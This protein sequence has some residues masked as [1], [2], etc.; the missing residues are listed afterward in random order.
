VN[1]NAADIV[2]NHFTFTGMD[3]GTDFDP[4]WQDFIGN[5]AG[6]ADA[7]P[8]PVGGG[9]N[10]VAGRLDLMAANASRVARN[11][12]AMIVEEIVPAGGR[13]ARQ[14]FRSSPRCQ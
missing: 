1:G 9:E 8:R 12:A 7:A 11:R 5:G 13:R 14:P 2:A 3:P 10:A 6:A 4:K